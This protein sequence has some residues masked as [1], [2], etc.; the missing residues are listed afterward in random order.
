MGL[1]KTSQEAAPLRSL[2]VQLSVGV[3]PYVLRFK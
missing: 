3:D 2:P 1:G